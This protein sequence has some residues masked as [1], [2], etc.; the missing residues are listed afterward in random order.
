MA[1]RA[2]AGHV[3]APRPRSLGFPAQEGHDRS[4]SQRSEVTRKPPKSE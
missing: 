2:P 4:G 1:A 3:A